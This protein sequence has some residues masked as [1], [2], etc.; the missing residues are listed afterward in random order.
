MSQSNTQTATPA[1]A[2]PAAPKPQRPKDPPVPPEYQA[3]A[4]MK[5]P[6]DELVKMLQDP[7]STE[8]Q[9]SKACMQ[10]AV[11]GT[12]SA[13]G[14]LAAMLTDPKMAHYARFGLVPITDASVDDALRATLPKV[15]GALLVNVIDAIGQRKDAKAVDAL[16]GLVQNADPEVALAAITSLG[17]IGAPA[18]AALLSALGKTQG[19]LHAAAAN[20]YLVSA[21]SWI[22]K[23]DRNKALEVYGRLTQSDIP[24]P[25]RLGA[26]NSIIAVETAINRPK[27]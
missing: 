6:A 27:K 18:D 23:G 22:A 3:A 26:H 9:K 8:F 19:K 11:V 12:K 1:P 10:L 4:I 15:K 7:K 20:A 17:L 2:K 16:S 13:V 21:E 14:P 24:K 5:L 25:I